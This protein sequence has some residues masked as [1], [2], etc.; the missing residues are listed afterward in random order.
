V[1]SWATNNTNTT[2]WSTGPASNPTGSAP[3]TMSQW[4]TLPQALCAP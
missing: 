2:V 1:V 4:A 3:R